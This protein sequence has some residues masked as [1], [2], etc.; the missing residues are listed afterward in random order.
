VREALALGPTSRVVVINSEGATDRE[1]Y[2]RLVARI[3]DRG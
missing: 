3:A 2:E 1:L